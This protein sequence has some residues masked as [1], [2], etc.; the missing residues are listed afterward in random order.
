MTFKQWVKKYA[1]KKIDYDGVYG[2]QCVD[3]IKHYIKNV[4]GFT[5]KSIGNAKNYWINRD[6]DYIKSMF[7][8]I[9]NT[10]DF[11]PKEG[12]V[13]VRTSGKCGHLGVVCDKATTEYFY[14]YEQNAG[15]TGQGMTKHKHTDWK[16]INFLRPKKQKVTTAGGRLRAYKTINDAVCSLYIPNGTEVVLLCVDAGLKNIDG[17]KYQMSKIK[18]NDSVYFVAD[19]YISI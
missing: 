11:V 7:I 9:K 2:V 13:F 3:L 5:P 1:G 14:A 16:S 19:K 8:P 10:P 12:D 4:L 6:S 17:K 15:G 18:Y